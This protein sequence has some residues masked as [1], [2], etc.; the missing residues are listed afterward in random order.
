[1]HSPLRTLQ[2]TSQPG[3]KRR[4]QD[5]D[6]LVQC[7]M[8][9]NDIDE[10]INPI[11]HFLHAVNNQG[12][13]ASHPTVFITFVNMKE[14]KFEGYCNRIGERTHTEGHSSHTF[15]YV[16]NFEGLPNFMVDLSSNKPPY[17]LTK[18]AGS[19]EENM[20]KTLKIFFARRNAPESLEP[21]SATNKSLCVLKRADEGKLKTI[22]RIT[23]ETVD[24]DIGGVYRIERA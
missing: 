11:N 5:I 4:I 21:V 6:S 15:L 12:E 17:Y 19:W 7:R 9:S 10:C 23:V 24:V 8:I 22:D 14:K 13:D 20:K 3:S 2:L 1:M 16:Q 18:I